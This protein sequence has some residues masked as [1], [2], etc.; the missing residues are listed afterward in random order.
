MARIV[1]PA[2]FYVIVHKS[3]LMK[4]FLY[5]SYDLI[6]YPSSDGKPL[7]ENTLQ[8]RWIV[9][10]FTN[11]QYLFLGKTAFVAADLLWYPVKGH[12]DISRAPDIMVALGRPPGDRPSYLQW[13]EE[14]QPPTVAIEVLSPSNGKKEMDEKHDFYDRYG[15]QEYLI[16]KPETNEFAVSLRDETGRLTP[17][18]VENSGFQSPNLGIWLRVVDGKLVVQ[19]PDGTRLKDF[20]QTVQEAEIALELAEK[21]RIKAEKERRR[22]EAE[23]EKAAQAHLRAEA[24]KVNAEKERLRAEE[25]KVNAENE[26]LRAEEERRRA[27]QA[28]AELEALRK[29]LR[30]LG[31]E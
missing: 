8:L 13:K 22:A 5:S 25:E 21:E 1:F 20:T 4:G 27:E 3:D 17:V 16:I 7:A 26:R 28:E 9:E 23:K 29:K 2:L 15:I 6:H 10:L 30:D 12:A 24:E 11:L 14:N 31:L 18:V 19:L